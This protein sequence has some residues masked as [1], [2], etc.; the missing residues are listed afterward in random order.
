MALNPYVKA[1]LKP[2]AAT[3][4]HPCVFFGE[5]QNAG[6]TRIESLHLPKFFR[7][8]CYGLHLPNLKPVAAT[9]FY[10]FEAH[11]YIRKGS[12]EV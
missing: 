10:P 4:V 12:A 9:M 8:A 1:H 2:V 3:H 7:E 6:N 5:A 11:G